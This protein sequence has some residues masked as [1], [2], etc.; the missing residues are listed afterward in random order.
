MGDDGGRGAPRWEVDFD[1]T[2][3]LVIWET[4]QAC[5]LTCLHC[6][7][8]AVPGPIPGELSFD[9]GR[10]LIDRVAEMGAPLMVLSGG[11]PSTRPDLPDLIRH[12]KGLGLRMATIPAATPRLSRD[13]I[14][15]LRDAGLDQI[16]FSLDF[17][18]A[19][20]HDGFRG[21][22][23]AFERTMAALGWAREAGL[24]V[25]INTCVWDQSA[26]FIEDV[27]RL[28]EDQGA[29]FWEVFFLVPVGRGALLKGLTAG[30]CEEIFEPLRRA[31]ARGR[32][33]LK[34]TEAPHY[35]RYLEERGERELG[36]SRHSPGEGHPV[37][38]P[39]RG[40]NA[41]NGFLFVSHMGEIYPSGFL[42]LSAGNARVQAPADVYRDSPLFRALRDPDRLKGRC[43]RC[44]FRRICGG[45]R[46]RAYAI[47]GDWL[48]EDPW[49][50]YVPPPAGGAAST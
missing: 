6:R 8:E 3:F 32:Y 4:T 50:A 20:L 28:V 30:R 43:G 29:V 23:G 12:G 18:R 33:V 27:A 2:P 38:M 36:R 49:C 44:P 47:S 10:R 46:S 40:V 25:Q 35:R 16:A 13:L 26:A 5:E 42:P 17:P 41:G 19:D 22:P 45:S 48:E 9:E 1:R 14:L 21:S 39:S 15:R 31:Q 37:G 24:P 7:A 34:V 11:D